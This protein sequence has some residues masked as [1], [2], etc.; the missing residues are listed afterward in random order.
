MGDRLGK[1]NVPNFRFQSQSQNITSFPWSAPS[2]VECTIVV[3]HCT[4]SSA[5]RKWMTRS[6]GVGARMFKSMM[7][8]RARAF[9]V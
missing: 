6:T 2:M 7:Q 8:V 1:T 3:A 4:I 5:P 9:P